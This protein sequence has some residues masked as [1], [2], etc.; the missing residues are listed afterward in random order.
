MFEMKKTRKGKTTYSPEF[1][2]K[3]V[4]MYIEEGYGYKR[5]CKELGIPSTKTIRLWVK[6]YDET[7]LDGL[8]ERRGKSKSPLKGGPRKKKLSLEEENRRLKA[9]NE[10]LKKLRSLARR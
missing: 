3:A 2:L 4:K 10:Y 6:N 7:G 9:E 8:E 1:K 5:V